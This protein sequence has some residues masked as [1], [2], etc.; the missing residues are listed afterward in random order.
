MGVAVPRQAGSPA[1]TQ[2]NDVLRIHTEKEQCEAMLA[3]TTSDLRA[4]EARASDS[5]GVRCQYMELQSKFERL[6][7]P[8][9]AKRTKRIV[10]MN[11]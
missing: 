1:S 9:S 6:V 8:C 7:S 5:W 11:S 10:V 2:V 3:G 4:A